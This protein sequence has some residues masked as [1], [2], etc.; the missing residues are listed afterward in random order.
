MK[1]Q[2]LLT[3]F[4]VRVDNGDGS[5]AHERN[6]DFAVFV[7]GKLVQSVYV[8]DDGQVGLYVGDDGYQMEVQDIF[9][10]EWDVRIYVEVNK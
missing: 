3:Y 10:T 9:D 4:T 5:S 1:T 8:W 6:D 7:N 2:E